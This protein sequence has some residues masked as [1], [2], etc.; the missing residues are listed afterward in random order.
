[1]IVAVLAVALA[2]GPQSLPPGAGAGAGAG[3]GADERGPRPM[4]AEDARA[5]VRCGDVLITPDGERV[6]YSRVRGDGSQA[7]FLMDALLGERTAVPVPGA[8]GGRAF[9]FAPDGARLSMLRDDAQL[10]LARVPDGE[11]LRASDHA[12]GIGRYAWTP[13]GRSVLFVASDGLWS[14]DVAT[15]DER[16]VTSGLFGDFDVAP[17]GESVVIEAGG[18]LLAVSLADGARTTLTGGGARKSDVR[19]SEDGARV[20]FVDRHGLW[21]LA[22][23][24][25]ATELVASGFDAIEEPIWSPDGPA[26]VFL[27]R[28]GA[29]T[30][31]WR[32]DLDTKELEQ[33]SPWPGTV[34]R[35]SFSRNRRRVAYAYSDTYS[36]EEVYSYVAGE[37]HTQ[38]LTNA[39]PRIGREVEL[40]ETI[41]VPWT[42][43][44]GAERDALLLVPD[45]GERVPLVVHLGAFANRFDPRDHV[46]AGLG[47][48]TLRL[49]A[50][51]AAD[52]ER[53]LDAAVA[54]GLVDP[55]RVVLRGEDE[56]AELG[57]ALAASSERFRAFSLARSES[58]E[59]ARVPVRLG[60]SGEDE[61][62][63]LRTHARRAQ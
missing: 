30:G 17:D 24:S 20:L 49:G 4:T 16:H 41:A 7:F 2:A 59:G 54:T 53:A 5:V 58:V 50:R 38:H 3:V 11:A 10:W 25:G 42:G 23:A 45:G 21:T 27:G 43:A 18:E 63:W 32:M 57:A 26:L 34:V 14:L 9:G 13:D 39:N 28:R 6:F 51:S 33:L 46:Q 1:M 44:D 47:L 15:N 12:G 19:W 29:S 55:Q 36:T 35:A 22:A 48:A 52:V 31:F 40:A 8:A 61:L 37:E 62:E 60:A 56:G